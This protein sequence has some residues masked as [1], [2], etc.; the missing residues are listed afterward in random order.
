MTSLKR[1]VACASAVALATGTTLAG[2]GIAAA[3]DEA[4]STG[5]L[6]SSSLDLGDTA[7][8]L[9]I[10][11]KAL[12]G[13]VTVIP[14]DEGGPT[15]T[16]TN[17]GT[18]AEECLGFAAPYS[19]ITDNDL[20]VGYDTKDLAAGLALVNAIE[21]GPDVSLLLGDEEGKPLV[22]VNDPDFDQNIA[23]EITGLLFERLNPETPARS[24][25]VEP[26]E[27]V[28]WTLDVPE[29][30]AAAGVLCIAEPNDGTSEM[31]TNFGIDK[32]VVADQ[33]NGKIPGG[34]LEIVSPAMISGGSVEA[35][36]GALGSLES[37]S[38]GGAEEPPVVAP[39]E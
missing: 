2:A 39:A 29:S 20:D 19:T 37:A 26:G 16:Y 32:Q 31:V 21:A 36:A 34:S 18:L 9:E 33:I 1:F 7:A 10:A 11:A 25:V 4:E 30:P 15:V 3:Q 23:Q 8:D 28:S 17:S 35:G 14:N 12:N 22:E 13:P 5:S 6:S 24:V 38:D 27:S